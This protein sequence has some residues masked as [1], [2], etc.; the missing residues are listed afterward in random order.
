MLDILPSPEV[1]QVMG[2]GQS[3]SPRMEEMRASPVERAGMAG[4][5]Q[6][7]PPPFVS[8]MDR[9]KKEG[10]FKTSHTHTHTPSSGPSLKSSPAVFLAVLQLRWVSHSLLE[11]CSFSFFLFPFQLLLNSELPGGSNVIHIF[12]SRFSH[13]QIGREDILPE[14]G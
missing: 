4:A 5:L 9:G 2:E 7:H 1:G 14:L 11:P 10:T 3:R 13:C 12:G 8:S 6:L